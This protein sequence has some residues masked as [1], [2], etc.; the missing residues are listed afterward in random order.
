M[1]KTYLLLLVFTL[2]LVLTACGGSSNG[3]SKLTLEEGQEQLIE[4]SES[5][6]NGE[7][8]SQEAKEMQN[9]LKDNM[10]SQNELLIRTNNNITAFKAVPSWAKS[11]NILEPK[12]LVLVDS[13]SRVVKEGSGYTDSFITLYKGDP[14]LLMSEGKRITKDLGLQIDYDESG[15]FMSAGSVD[16]YTVSITV[17][18]NG[19]GLRMDYSATDLSNI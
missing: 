8:T 11:L 19:K 1:K 12:G 15:I 2:S 9:K 16:K 3:S 5:L 6:M 18:D 13:D 7:I 14:E 10:E 17:S 4:I